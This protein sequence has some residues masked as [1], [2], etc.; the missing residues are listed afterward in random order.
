MSSPVLNDLAARVAAAAPE[1]W[2]GAR[3]VWD[4]EGDGTDRPAPAY[5]L[6]GGETREV[7]LGPF[8]NAVEICRLVDRG[9]VRLVL[10]VEASGRFEAAVGGPSEDGERDEPILYVRDEDEVFPPDRGDQQAAPASATPAGDPEEAVRLFREL[11][12]RRAEILGHEEKLPPPAEDLDDL[13]EALGFALPADLRA[14]Y[15]LADGDGTLTTP[16]FDRHPWISSEE[17]GDEDDEWV[18]ISLDWKHE[19][20]RSPVLDALPANTVRRSLLRPG[21]I[22]FAHDTGG[23]WL[24]VDMDPGP[25][26]RPGQVIAIGTDYTEA[27]RYVADSVTTYLRRLVEALRRGDHENRG[28]DLFIDVDLPDLHEAEEDRVFHLDGGELQVAFQGQEYRATDVEDLAY[29]AAVPTL[30]S[31]DLSGPGGPDLT[32]LSALPVEFLALDFETVDPSPLAGHPE[33]R[34]LAITS[35]TPVDLAPLRTVPHLWALNVAAAPVPDLSVIADLPALRYLEVTRAQWDELCHRD[36]LPPF[37][38]VG[39]HPDP[40]EREW[41]LNIPW[42]TVHGDPPHRYTATLPPA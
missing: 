11:M 40:P 39:I 10:T 5:T 19:P 6:P 41:P 2:T 30:R 9:P 34:S 22:R 4:V 21:W 8:E 32:P 23:N 18:D 42:T 37:T 27:P 1:G 28:D 20:Q 38:A 3:L 25:A 7:D 29:L 17:L 24:A 12:R 35:R 36:D 15:G 33:L 31:A 14:L 16:V 26:G 13:E